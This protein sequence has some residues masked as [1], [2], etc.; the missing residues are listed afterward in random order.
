MQ[1]T[2]AEGEVGA[3]KVANFSLEIHWKSQHEG[4]ILLQGDAKGLM[5]EM[6]F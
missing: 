2:Q 4:V 3:S 6:G 5:V 1:A